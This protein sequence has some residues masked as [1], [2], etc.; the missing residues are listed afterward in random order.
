MS[1]AYVLY[2]DYIFRFDSE[3]MM[4]RKSYTPIEFFRDLPGHHKN[5]DPFTMDEMLM[6]SKTGIKRLQDHIGYS[7]GKIIMIDL[8]NFINYLKRREV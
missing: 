2:S 8:K 5:G 1:Y 4:F 7:I 6:H 3:H